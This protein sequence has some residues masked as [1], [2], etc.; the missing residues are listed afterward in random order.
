MIKII[1][2]SLFTFA[3]CGLPPEDWKDNQPSNEKWMASLGTSLEKLTFA[4]QFLPRE[5]LYG[6][7]LAGFFE[8]GDSIYS[9]H[10]DN[11]GNMIRLKYDEENNIWKQI[12][13]E[14]LVCE[15][16]EE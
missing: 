9:D 12:K 11:H 3:A 4:S 2:V 7:R 5:K 6:L 13:Y 16:F 15:G 14:T 1:I 8:I 10:C